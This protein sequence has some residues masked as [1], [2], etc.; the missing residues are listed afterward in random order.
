[1]IL[2]KGKKLIAMIAAALPLGVVGT[3]FFAANNSIR[4]SKASAY[5]ASLT[6]AN[7]PELTNG[8]GTMID[9]KNVTTLPI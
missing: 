4:P 8:E 6:N 3:L 1:M 9:E 5:T 2:V 7:S